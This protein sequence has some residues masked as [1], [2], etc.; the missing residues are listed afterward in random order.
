M[1][2]GVAGVAGVPFGSR[3]K[4]RFNNVLEFLQIFVQKGAEMDMIDF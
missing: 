3:R 1:L 4:Y 2:A